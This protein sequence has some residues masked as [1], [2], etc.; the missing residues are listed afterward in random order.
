MQR[1][2]PFQARRRI[3][4]GRSGTAGV[5]LFLLLFLLLA[6]ASP[7]PAGAQQVTD[8]LLRAVFPEADR[9]GETG[10]D[11]PVMRVYAADEAGSGE[12]LVGYAFLTSDIPPESF[13]YNAPI[14][15][16]V[17]MDLNGVL[18][19]AR[20]V[21]YRESL[22]STRGDFL[23]RGGVQGQ[24][25]GKSITDAFRVRQDVNNI[26]GA[27]ITV[28]AMALGIRNASRRVWAAYLREPD[29]ALA[30]G[31]PPR[32]GTVPAETL[33]RLTWPEI[34]QFDLTRELVVAG[35]GFPEVM[36]S[37]TY[38]RDREVGEMIVGAARYG[39]ALTRAGDAAEGRHLMLLGMNGD[40]VTFFPTES[41]RFRQG[42][43]VVEVAAADFTTMGTIADG[44]AQGE[45]RRAGI[46][47]VDPALDM[48][49]PFD[50]EVEP[51]P[52]VIATGP[53]LV[54][55][56]AP[57]VVAASE[58]ESAAGDPLSGGAEPPGG[59]AT[60]S[61]D[62]DAV[63]AG[64][65]APDANA[66]GG[67]PPPGGDPLPGATAAT[68]PAVPAG[69]TGALQPVAA[70]SDEELIA[71]LFEDDEVEASTLSRTLEQTSW[72][73]V[74]FLLVLLS[75]VSVAFVSK[76]APWRAVALGVTVV[77]LGFVDR[78]FLSV[79]HIIAG[80]SVGP[81]VYL[82]DLSLLILVA[83]TVLTTLFLGRVFCGFLCPFGAIQDA[84]EWLVPR[85]FRRELPE[86][87]HRRALLA[88][89]GILGLV[90]LPVL[91][92]LPITLFHYFEPFGTVFYW[93][94]SILLWT[95][96]GGILVASAIIPR[97]YCRYACPLGA[98]L[99]IGSMLSPFR[100]RRVEQCSVC[101]VCE[102]KCPT[103]AIQGPRIDFKE[104][105]RCNVC[106]RQLIEQAG[107]CRHDMEKIRPRLVQLEVGARGGVS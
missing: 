73:R 27:T 38:L 66:S 64:D 9:F 84:L 29:P 50:V 104:C 48:T 75:G 34:V 78:G 71:F 11:P 72:P 77:F 40:N 24:F 15:V 41:I 81:E 83:F 14:E 2:A 80:I 12:R 96:A 62:A 4:S 57:V 16:L 30:G 60:P 44:R 82:T 65:G 69:D 42:D 17:G 55:D 20:V 97:F 61:S 39:E 106:E 46:L 37:L 63:G 51:R 54:N 45:F 3:P 7:T 102:R 86:P 101:T 13:G 19:G 89:Y 87:V 26:T 36:V 22:R 105:V 68:G 88:K 100:I 47:L 21:D 52:G 18:T 6:W 79:S 32:I 70:L 10:G 58:S 90:L 93:S 76:R 28:A 107:V 74:A 67:I 8:A 1:G 25:A 99:A 91:V 103:G 92:G 23:S 56:P 49:R 35:Q 5:L 31:A 33:A 95:I 53:Y 59:G 94:P 85:R 43:T 98:A